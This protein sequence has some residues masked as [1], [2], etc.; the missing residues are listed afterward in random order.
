MKQERLQA[1]CFISCCM[2]I[3]VN[4][5]PGFEYTSMYE[6]AGVEDNE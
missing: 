2:T 3:N 1:A 5:K 4:S 6:W